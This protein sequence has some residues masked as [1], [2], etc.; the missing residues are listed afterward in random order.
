[1]DNVEEFLQLSKD[2]EE[3]EQEILEHWEDAIDSFDWVWNN[4]DITDKLYEIKPMVMVLDKANAFGKTVLKGD[5]LKVQFS[6][7]I[8]AIEDDR[9]FYSVIV[10]ELLHAAAYFTDKTLDHK[11]A[12][13]KFADAVNSKSRLN[14]TETGEN[15]VDN[16]L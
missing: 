9:D 4:D 6:M 3:K 10:H 15:I 13:K 11:H 12:W 1:M 2:I 14:I 16:I 5:G 8:F 7:N